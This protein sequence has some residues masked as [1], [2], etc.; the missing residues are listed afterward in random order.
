MKNETENEVT[1]SLLIERVALSP[2]SLLLS[3]QQN[4]TYSSRSEMRRQDFLYYIWS[5]SEMPVPLS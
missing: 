3:G 4:I 2:L 5:S 1:F